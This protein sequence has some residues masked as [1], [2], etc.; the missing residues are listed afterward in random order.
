LVRRLTLVEARQGGS[1]V[2]A[3]AE[4][5]HSPSQGNDNDKGEH[6]QGVH[7]HDESLEAHRLQDELESARTIAAKMRVELLTAQERLH[8]TE[9]SLSYVQQK[10][11]GE[12]GRSNDHIEQ[13]KSLIGS[14]R[15]QP[16]AT[17]QEYASS[18]NARTKRI[19]AVDPEKLA[20]LMGLP[21]TDLRRT[22]PGSG[23]PSPASS[24]RRNRNPSLRDALKSTLSSGGPPSR[25]NL[26][27][28]PKDFHHLVNHAA[29]YTMDSRWGVPS[30]SPFYPPPRRGRGTQASSFIGRGAPERGTWA[31][32]SPCSPIMS[33]S[34]PPMVHRTQS[35]EP[36]EVLRVPR[37]GGGFGGGYPRSHTHPNAVEERGGVGAFGGMNASERGDGISSTANMRI[38]RPLHTGVRER[39]EGRDS[40]PPHPP[41]SLGSPS[42]PPNPPPTPHGPHFR[43]LKLAYQQFGGNLLNDN[44]F[45]RGIGGGGVGA[46]GRKGERKGRRGKIN[47][48]S[49]Y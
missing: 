44:R 11:E 45:A 42:P 12:L 22:P 15:G 2:V 37:V 1:P 31:R 25:E 18:H 48:P 49:L 6:G 38:Y 10:A 24:G 20:T 16:P 17:P 23:P 28:Q 14:R 43:E 9:N 35:H 13:L 5:P 34:S 8:Y 21:P 27:Q 26:M 19:A 40:P 4:E 33:G 29:P 47:P 3:L 36:D 46:R 7:W 32:S 39:R 41:S 30:T